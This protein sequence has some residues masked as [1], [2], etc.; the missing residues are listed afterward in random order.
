MQL[1]ELDDLDV[2]QQ[3]VVAVPAVGAQQH[4][5]AEPGAAPG[6]G[7]DNGVSTLVRQAGREGRQA[8]SLR[9]FAFC[10]Q[11]DETSQKL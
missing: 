6:R 1:A 11:W 4:G 8:I 7:D 10:V 5:V 9:I 2:L 3:L